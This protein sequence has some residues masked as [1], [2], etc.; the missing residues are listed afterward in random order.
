MPKHRHT[1][2]FMFT[3]SVYSKGLQPVSPYSVHKPPD[4][5]GWE[6]GNVLNYTLAGKAL[7]YVSGKSDAPPSLLAQY[8]W[9]GLAALPF[10]YVGVNLALDSM[11]R[12]KK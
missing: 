5:A 7:D 10:L 2:L 3:P 1:T 6:Y 4:T 8:W 12:K 9:V 11:Q